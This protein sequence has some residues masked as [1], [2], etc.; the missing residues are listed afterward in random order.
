MQA[1]IT[2]IF[3]PSTFLYNIQAP[4]LHIHILK[5][6]HTYMSILMC[7]YKQIRNFVYS[8]KRLNRTQDALKHTLTIIAIL[9][10]V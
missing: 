5:N 3:N 4:C 8:K 6:I 1:I 10:N 7:Q 9:M 2:K